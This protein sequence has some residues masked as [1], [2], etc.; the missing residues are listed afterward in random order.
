M[1]DNKVLISV[2]PVD[3]ADKVNDPEK[4]AADVIE[5]AK[6]GAGM[7]HLHVR[8]PDG[9]LTDNL[10]HLKKTVDLIRAKSDIIIEISTGGV[11]DLTIQQ[12]CAPLSYDK[13]EAVSLNV[14]SVNLG[15]AVYQNP[16]KDV[17]YC[18][19]EIVKSGKTPEVEVFEI[20]MIHTTLELAKEFKM[21]SPLLFS[22]VLGHIG[23]MPATMEALIAM[24]SFIPK[25]MLWG[26][27]HAH[28][29]NNDIIEA[30]IALGAKTVRIGFEDSHHVDE[31]TIAETNAPMVE[32]VRGILTAFGKVPMTPDEARSYFNIIK[33]G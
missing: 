1:K 20:G 26:I 13:A 11:S 15:D 19:K 2:A 21:S 12:R 17:K 4:I 30:A 8:N 10:S 25:D 16:I 28:R 6:L 22:I 5:C 14:G 33:R 27:T 3:A 7:V 23:A 29:V 32:K 24:R 31:N 18:V 9:S